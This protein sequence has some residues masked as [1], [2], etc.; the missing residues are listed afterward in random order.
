MSANVLNLHHT[1]CL[2]KFFIFLTFAF[3]YSAYTANI[4][5]LLQ[6]PSKNIRTMEDL[7]NSKIKLGVSDTPYNRYYLP[8]GE[9]PFEKKVY[10]EKLAPPGKKDNFMINPVGVAKIRQGLFAFIAE[11]SIAYKIME[12]T[13]Y[14]HEKC[15]LVNI[16][17]I[18]LSDPHMS[19]RKRSPYKEILKVK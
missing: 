10:L 13:F 8:R 12:D 16:E 11:E 17:F 3:L 15:A 1:S 19:I 4:V 5:S 2:F 18:K 6:S 7:Y 9:T 14:E